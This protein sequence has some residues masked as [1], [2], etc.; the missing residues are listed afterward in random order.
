MSGPDA[1]IGKID[2]PIMAISPIYDMGSLPD[3]MYHWSEFTTGK[4]Q[5]LEVKAGHMDVLDKN[6]PMF[7]S[8]FNDMMQFY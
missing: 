5:L 3:E 8:V 4:F 1:D 2:T 6:S 7:T